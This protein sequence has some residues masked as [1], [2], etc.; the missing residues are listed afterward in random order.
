MVHHGRGGCGPDGFVSLLAL[1]PALPSP[2]R[3]RGRSSLL[4]WKRDFQG[5]RI[6]WSPDLGEPPVDPGVT[7]TIEAQL[8]VFDSLG[9]PVEP[10][11][12]DFSD[13]DEVFKGLVV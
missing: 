1:I 12:P 8:E 2:C 7:E 6:A 4:P 3:S 5:V 11:H 13:A 10:G 9:A